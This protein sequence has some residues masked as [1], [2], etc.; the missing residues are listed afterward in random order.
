MVTSLGTLATLCQTILR[1]TLTHT[2][3][4]L[5]RN[6]YP[7]IKLHKYVVHFSLIVTPE[8]KK[9]KSLMDFISANFPKN[10]PLFSDV[11]TPQI[12][13]QW[14]LSTFS[15]SFHQSCNLFFYYLFFCLF[16]VEGFFIIT[17]SSTTILF[18]KPPLNKENRKWKKEKKKERSKNIAPF[19]FFYLSVI[20]ANCVR[21]RVFYFSFY[22]SLSM[23]FRLFLMTVFAV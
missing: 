11:P 8:R 7:Y 15:L 12:L 4:Y 18:A 21:S 6:I 22:L 9:K 16:L 5:N 14:R 13:F 10:Y 19:Y 17:R 20:H 2:L 1:S 23:S 3:T